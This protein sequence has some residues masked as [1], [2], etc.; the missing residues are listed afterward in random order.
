[1]DIAAFLEVPVV[2]EGVEEEE[3]LRAL[4]DMRCDLVQGYYFS[5]PVPPERF[6]KLIEKEL[7]EKG[8]WHDN[9]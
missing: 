8:D 4:K 1:M 6:G 5:P 3:Q 9:H 7:Q 2:A